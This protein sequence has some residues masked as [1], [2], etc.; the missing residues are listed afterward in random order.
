MSKLKYGGIE[1]SSEII[2][3][4]KGWTANSHGDPECLARNESVDEDLLMLTPFARATGHSRHHRDSA[5]R[6]EV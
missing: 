4:T 2:P 6:P 3:I 5:A 1:V